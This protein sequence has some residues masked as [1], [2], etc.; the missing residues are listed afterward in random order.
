M[1]DLQKYDFDYA[2][3]KH[4]SY[5]FNTDFDIT[6]HV[7][8]KDSSYLFDGRLE[9]EVQAFELIIEIYDNP[10]GIKPPLDSKMPLTIATIFKDFCE[11]FNERVIIYICDSSD[12]RQEARRRKFNQWVEQFKG[13]D[14]LKLDTAIKENAKII[15]HSSVI[16]RND[17]PF[18]MQIFDAFLN[19]ARE[20]EK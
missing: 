20:Q 15:Y 12:I 7:K 5:Y 14:Y 8:F 19:L 17:N 18:K 3:G 2:G 10:M 4:N 9:F 13:D 11:K 16:V 1:T 6:Y